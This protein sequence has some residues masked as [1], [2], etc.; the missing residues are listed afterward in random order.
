MLIFPDR[1]Q[2]A[3]TGDWDDLGGHRRYIYD[4]VSMRGSIDFVQ[5]TIADA[6][7]AMRYT[8]ADAENDVDYVYADITRAYNSTRF[9]DDYNPARVS[10]VVR[11][12]VYF[13]PSQPG[14]DPVRLVI[15]DRAT[16]TNTKF[17]KEWLFHT[18][19]EP[20]VNGTATNGQPVR[21]GHGNGHVTYTGATRVMDQHGC[22]LERAH[23]PDASPTGVPDHR[24]DWRP[25]RRGPILGGGLPRVRGSVRRSAPIR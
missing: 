14:T 16:T 22:R 18:A 5:N 1:T 2:T 15:F 21:G 4:Q 17:E 11:Q 23:V 10:E 25:K 20:M 9:K 8:L 12:M 3:S 24:Q 7:D 13:R 6:L 19:A